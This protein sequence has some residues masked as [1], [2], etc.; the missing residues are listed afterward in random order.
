MM[1]KDEMEWKI[2]NH[3]EG[4][5]VLLSERS[6]ER[7]AAEGILVDIQVNFEEEQ[8]P[9]LISL[10]RVFDLADV[11]STWSTGTLSSRLLAPS[12]SKYTTRSRI[13][14]GAPLH[15]LVS[16][17]GC[18]R[19]TSALSDAAVACELRTGMVE[20][21]GLVEFELRLFVT[22][23]SPLKSYRVTLYLDFSDRRYEDAIRD[24]VRWWGEDCG[25]LEAS[26]PDIAKRPMYSTWYSYHQNIEPDSIIRQCEIAKEMGMESVIVDDGWQ[27]DDG[28]RGYAYCGD[29]E[30]AEKKIPAMKDF[31]NAIH[32]LG[33]RFLLWY[34]VP[35][36]GKYSHAFAQ[37][38][39]MYLG[40]YESHGEVQ[41]GVLDPRYPQVREYLCGLYQKALLD[42]DLDGFKLDF[43]DSFKLYPDTPA[44]DPRRD[45]VSL[46]DGVD[47]LLKEITESLK[48]I[49]PDVMIEFRQSYI[50][51]YIRRYGNMVRVGD[52]PMNAMINRRASIDL[53]LISGNTAVHSDMIR[54]NPKESV[55]SAAIQMIATLFA[56]P[57]ISVRFE[58]IGEDHRKMLRFY[59]DYWMRN[60]DVLL[61]GLLYAD[62]PEA[63][64]SLASVRKDGICMSLLYVY[65]VVDFDE[66]IHRLSVINAGGGNC[67]SVRLHDEGVFN[68]TIYNCMGEC[69]S[70]VEL[71]GGRVVDIVVPRAGILEIAR[72]AKS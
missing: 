18:N 69:L 30:V 59:L 48:A 5:K 23:A 63:W 47:R 13:S 67:I 72:T 54:W 26:V 38:S 49:K 9:Q 60:R 25:F 43:I 10:R 34:S 37:F 51:P 3:N 41:Y 66:D 4:A 6:L 12:W 52:C 55:E 20:E 16:L 7:G 2:Q 31:V 29:W 50:G 24:A 14:S 21:T 32:K 28:S 62:D 36:V 42:W 53:R 71:T 61:N 65:K 22:P 27:T 40:Y 64:Y 44:E 56:V 17:G 39:E 68:Y 35:F 58:E 57:Q 15:A 8:I 33:M 11:Y 70:S 1:E 19:L 46:E 45:T